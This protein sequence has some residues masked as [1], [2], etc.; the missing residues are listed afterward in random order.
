M[1]LFK[2]K[3]RRNKNEF[4]YV[5]QFLTKMAIRENMSMFEELHNKWDLFKNVGDGSKIEKTLV[6]TLTS[7]LK[8]VDTQT[9]DYYRLCDLLDELHRKQEKRKA[10]MYKWVDSFCEFLNGKDEKLFIEKYCKT[11]DVDCMSELF[12]TDINKAYKIFSE[13]DFNGQVEEENDAEE[14]EDVEVAATSEELG[15]EE[16]ETET[17][18]IE[19]DSEE[20]SSEG[21]NEPENDVKD[22]KNKKVRLVQENPD[23]EPKD[24]PE[25]D[26][27]L[28]LMNQ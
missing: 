23:F 26:E 15:T 8:A 9:K 13:I 20:M 5:K 17:E 4:A 10:K 11:I 2:K 14:P 22:D 1:G 24:N 25:G 6:G 19:E 28:N 12:K 21:E 27:I 3:T 18:E 7:N 16:T